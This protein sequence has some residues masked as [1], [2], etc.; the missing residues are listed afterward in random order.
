[1]SWIILMRDSFRTS[2]SATAC[3]P[4]DSTFVSVQDAGRA[5]IEQQECAFAK[6]LATSAFPTGHK[7]ELANCH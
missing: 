5:D 4:S 7:R 3:G 2:I 1:M 6:S